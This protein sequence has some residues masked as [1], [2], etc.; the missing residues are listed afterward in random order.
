MATLFLII[1][2]ICCLILILAILLQAG[3][4]ADLA[5]AFGGMGS[6]QTFG[7]RGQATILS[8]LTTGAAV[9]FMVTSLALAITMSGTGGASKM[10]GFKGAGAPAST[11]PAKPGATPVKPGAPAPAAP[12]A[13][14]PAPAAPAK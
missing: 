12:A 13:P 9:I 4:S 10:R 7:P 2:I 1:H 11:A 5:G 6:Q 8:R 14:A 3:K